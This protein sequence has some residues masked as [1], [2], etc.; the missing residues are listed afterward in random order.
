MF[1]GKFKKTSKYA[2]FLILKQFVFVE[3]RR[4]SL[5]RLSYKVE[6]IKL[7]VQVVSKE[8]FLKIERSL[9]KQK[10]EVIILYCKLKINLE[11]TYMY[12]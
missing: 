1:Q 12:L 10:N 11:T 5:K 9:L 8:I 4:D 7:F 6:R 3:F 2:G